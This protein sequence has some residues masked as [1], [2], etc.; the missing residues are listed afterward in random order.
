[1]RLF[2]YV[3]IALLIAPAA[4][5]LEITPVKTAQDI[6]SSV[7]RELYQHGEELLT[8][9][10]C[11]SLEF[12]DLYFQAFNIQNNS[13]KSLETIMIETVKVATAKNIEE[14]DG[15]ELFPR[16]STFEQLLFVSIFSSDFRKLPTECIETLLTYAYDLQRS[17]SNN[18]HLLWFRSATSVGVLAYRSNKSALLIL[19][20]PRN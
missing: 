13:R 10:A 8:Q 1:M 15:L 19:S 7:T 14:D 9:S 16:L 3:L 4:Y 5:A 2:Q 6:E 18:Q 12:K 20:R 17:S 11:S